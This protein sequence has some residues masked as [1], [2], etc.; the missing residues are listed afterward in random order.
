MTADDLG[1]AEQNMG[2]CE[3]IVRW[4]S[5]IYSVTV[6]TLMGMDKAGGLPSEVSEF[7]GLNK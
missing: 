5:N 1:R 3:R 2:Q 7:I 6:L 4:D